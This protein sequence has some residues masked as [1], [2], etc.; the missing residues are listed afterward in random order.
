MI[1]FALICFATVGFTWA[2]YPLLVAVL[3]SLRKAAPREPVATPPRV[4]VIIATIA[5]DE[6]LAQRLADLERTQYPHERLDI[7]VA[8]DARRAS[9]TA[10]L[11]A[12]EIPVRIVRGDAPGGKALAL[13]AGV[14]AATGEFLVFSDVAQQ[15][16]PDTIPRL[17]AA[18]VADGRLGAVS[19]ALHIGGAPGRFSIANRYWQLERWLRRNEARVHSA[20]GVTGAVYAMQRVLWVPLPDGLIL[21]DLYTPMQLVLRGYRVGFDER[22]LAHD[23]RHFAPRDEYKRKA[24]TLTGVL[25]LC[26]WMPSV[27]AP[28]RNPIWLQFVSHKLLRLATPYL[29]GLGVV[30]VLG[31]AMVGH[32]GSYPGWAVGLVIAVLLLPALASRRVREGLSGAA[33]MQLAAVKATVNAFRGHWDVW[34]S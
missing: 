32:L 17:V 6:A 28:T 23:G 7:V 8:L 10:R 14:R 9:G 31:R 15:F 1:A 22:A 2:G 30:A 34:Q 4:T 21:D 16:E 12:R 20:V 11:E 29:L 24:R 33:Y 3:A 18:L 27:M 26:A 25:Q 5:D 19:G 13:N